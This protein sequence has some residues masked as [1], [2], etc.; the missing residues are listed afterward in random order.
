[1]FTNSSLSEES[2][3]PT[4]HSATIRNT[5]PRRQASHT[6]KTHPF[7]NCNAAASTSFRQHGRN[8]RLVN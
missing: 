4:G 1:M 3:D 6:L 2:Q 7:S 5:Q 8:I